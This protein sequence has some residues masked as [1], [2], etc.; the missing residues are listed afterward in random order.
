MLLCLSMSLAALGGCAERSC[1]DKS[2][3]WQAVVSTLSSACFS[4]SD[5]VVAGYSVPNSCFS[6][7]ISVGFA[8]VNR[9]EY[10]DSR[11]PA[12]EAS[13]LRSCGGTDFSCH[14]T[15]YTV[16]CVEHRCEIT[17]RETCGFP[18]AQVPDAGARDGGDLDAADA[19]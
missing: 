4:S 5:C 18:D 7:P 3:D 14:P 19:D 11:A 8:V 6:C 2:K 15:R 10:Y 9:A 13:F 16:G 1:A 17:A 12:L